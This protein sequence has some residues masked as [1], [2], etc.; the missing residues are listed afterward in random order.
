MNIYIY[1]NH[2]ASF[3]M[4]SG[5]LFIMGI[6]SHQTIRAKVSCPIY[7][8][9]ISCNHLSTVVKIWLTGYDHPSIIGN[10][11]RMSMDIPNSG[12]STMLQ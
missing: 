12:L 11:N 6:Q 9:V 10:P 1:M 7:S 2:A 8:W 4:G 3:G 5:C